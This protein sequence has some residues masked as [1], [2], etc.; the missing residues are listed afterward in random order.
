MPFCH[1]VVG[2]GGARMPNFPYVVKINIFG[3]LK[4]IN[5][6]TQVSNL[7]FVSGHL[8]YCYGYLGTPDLS[9]YKTQGRKTHFVVG[10]SV[11]MVVASTIITPT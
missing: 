1:V 11:R 3:L 7:L 6:I 10:L 4:L 2:M 8:N 5:R 9:Y